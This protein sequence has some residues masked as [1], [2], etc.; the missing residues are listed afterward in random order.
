MKVLINSENSSLLRLCKHFREEVSTGLRLNSKQIKQ[1]LLVL[2]QHN[3][4]ETNLPCLDPLGE[5]SAEDRMRRKELI[6]NVNLEMILNRIHFP[7]LLSICKEHFGVIGVIIMEELI[8]H[9]RQRIKR[10]C[11]DV[12]VRIS[13]LVEQGDETMLA[14]TSS[15][16]MLS[17]QNRLQNQII[18]IFE[19]MV[20]RRLIIALGYLELKPK[21]MDDTQNRMQTSMDSRSSKRNTRKESTASASA[22]NLSTSTSTIRTRK[23]AREPA[24]PQTSTDH[25]PVELR[26]MMELE[27]RNKQQEIE[28]QNSLML[29]AKAAHASHA[30]GVTDSAGSSQGLGRGGGRIGSRGGRAGRRGARGGASTAELLGS[31]QSALHAGIGEAGSDVGGMPATYVPSVGFSDTKPYSN[32][33]NLHGAPLGSS[34]GDFGPREEVYWSI[35]WEQLHREVRHQTCS[36]FAAQRMETLAGNVVD[37]ILESSMASEIGPLQVIPMRYHS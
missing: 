7:K 24:Q 22:A 29:A 5:N 15:F 2:H 10:L 11:A 1:A 17:E 27:E 33:V 37:V 12:E 20:Q 35:G 16:D 25:L 28:R 3:I 13:S 14:I 8:Y 6:Y 26:M 30:N 18:D 32:N 34:Q 4:L 31:Q 19:K 36:S 9:G 21:Q 23:R